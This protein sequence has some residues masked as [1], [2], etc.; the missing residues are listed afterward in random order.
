MEPLTLSR[1]PAP[2]Q[3]GA[4]SPRARTRPPASDTAQA[5]RELDVRR[6]TAGVALATALCAAGA[7]LP[8]GAS[9]ASWVR[10]ANCVAVN[11]GIAN[12]LTTAGNANRIIN[13]AATCQA[14]PPNRAIKIRNLLSGGGVVGEI[15]GVNNV[16]ANFSSPY[17]Y[18]KSQCW[19]PSGNPAG[20]LTCDT[21][22]Q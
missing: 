20:V 16:A 6:T 5:S 11:P 3:G 9:G 18:S 21:Y 13:Q 8:A 12:L 19:V 17:P 14:T 4:V 2:R 7:V 10:Y 15:G 1:V 22:T